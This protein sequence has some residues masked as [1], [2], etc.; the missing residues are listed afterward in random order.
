MLDASTLHR[1]AKYFMDSGR[2]ATHDEAMALLQSFGLTIH[3]SGSIALSLDEQVALLT[4]VNIRT[5]GGR[6]PLDRLL[7]REK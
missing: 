4:L 2:A 1:G 7:S 3:V 5:R 6:G